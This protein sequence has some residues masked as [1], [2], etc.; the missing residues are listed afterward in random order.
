MTVLC[1]GRIIFTRRV[2]LPRDVDSCMSLCKLIDH[3]FGK[4]LFIALLCM[5]FVNVYGLVSMFL[6]LLVLRVGCRI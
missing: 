4:E 6:S 1:V 5:Y 3:L 2:K